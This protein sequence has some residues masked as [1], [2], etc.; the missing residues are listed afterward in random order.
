V[1]SVNIF[2]LRDDIETPSYGS[3]FSTC[4]DLSF[5]PTCDIGIVKGYNRYNDAVVRHIHN[6][7]VLNTA[8]EFEI[9]P[10]DRL[11]VPT[12]LIFKIE[13]LHTIE[14]Y[15]DISKKEKPLKNFSIRLHPRSGLSL[16]RGLTLANSE[17]VV[18]VDYQEEV[19]VPLTN[20]SAVSQRIVRG[21]R[22]AQAEIV[23]NE[24]VNFVVV[25]TR[26]E[27]YSERSGGFGS[28]G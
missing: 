4:F 8:E 24:S 14:T 3:T 22:I 20:I 21:D 25:S 12:G 26:P 23:C 11:L 2:K 28:T 18:D 10:G 6:F 19:F 5:Q 15:A 17:G 13:Y 16:K 1:F 7:N 27:K 9:E